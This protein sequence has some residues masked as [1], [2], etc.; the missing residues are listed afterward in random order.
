MNNCVL[1]RDT[2]I[3]IDNLGYS[4]CPLTGSQITNEST[5]Y[6]ELLKYQC[7]PLC[8]QWGRIWE[9]K[10]QVHD[11][12]LLSLQLHRTLEALEVCVQLLFALDPTPRNKCVIFV[13]PTKIPVHQKGKGWLWAEEGWVGEAKKVIPSP[14][15]CPAV[16][17]KD[18][19]LLFPSPCN[20][21]WY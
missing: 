16:C 8:S 14:E 20:G 21:C 19:H 6:W 18:T 15:N 3:R 11:C 2:R 4:W 5:L 7:F 9:Q 17:S 10:G 1:G 12:S 13:G